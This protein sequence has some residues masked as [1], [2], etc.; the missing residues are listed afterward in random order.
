ML[1]SPWD[2][3]KVI[4]SFWSADLTGRRAVRGDPPRAGPE[5][6]PHSQGQW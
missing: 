6:W 4:V 3:I 5:W 2:K 1:G